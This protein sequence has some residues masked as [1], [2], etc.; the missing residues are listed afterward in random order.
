MK[1][2]VGFSCF[3]LLL[4]LFK[5][6]IRNIYYKRDLIREVKIDS[7]YTLKKYYPFNFGISGEITSYYLENDKSYFLGTCD[8]KEYIT[9]EKLNSKAIKIYKHSRRNMFGKGVK[10]IDS[11]IIQIL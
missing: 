6:T 3:F 11:S 9:A 8:E 4:Y 10:I 2:L 1:K 5:S 7:N